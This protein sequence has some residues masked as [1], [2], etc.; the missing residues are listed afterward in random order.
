MAQISATAEQEIKTLL[1]NW[2][3]AVN[4]QLA[5][6]TGATVQIGDAP[7]NLL[8]GS[9]IGQ[10]LVRIAAVAE[11][12]SAAEAAAAVEAAPNAAQAAYPWSEEL[13][14][15]ILEDCEAVETWLNQGLVFHKTPDAFWTSPVGF[16]I[17]RAKVWANQDHLITLSAA[18]EISGMSL[19]VLS[20]RMTRG[21]LP[22]YRDPN[23]K[24]PKHGRRVRL[25]DLHTLINE[26][27]DRIP[28]STTTYLLPQASRIPTPTTPRST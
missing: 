8:L 22:G 13:A 6:V 25:S 27:T 17:L 11:A 26:N 7:V 28:F 14:K 19:S 3:T 21:Q 4:T 9:E 1:V 15:Q 2:W 16:M 10:R 24:N 5:A 20:Q 18:A 23:I 12:I